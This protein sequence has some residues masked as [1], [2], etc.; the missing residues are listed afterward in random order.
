L[1]QFERR[2]DAMRS[3]NRR[4][5][6]VWKASPEMLERLANAEKEAEAEEAEM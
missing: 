1:L 6:I 2:G 4:G 3:V 5:R